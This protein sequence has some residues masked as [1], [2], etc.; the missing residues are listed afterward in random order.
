M[1]DKLCTINGVLMDVALRL[2]KGRMHAR[3]CNRLQ[4]NLR[5]QLPRRRCAAKSE[6]LR[7]ALGAP[8]P[9][10]TRDP[11]SH[12]HHYGL[13]QRLDRLLHFQPGPRLRNGGQQ[14]A[15]LRQRSSVRAGVRCH[16]LR[17]ILSLHKQR[18]DQAGPHR[19]GLQGLQLRSS[20]R[21]RR[22][23]LQLPQYPLGLCN[24]DAFP[25]CFFNGDA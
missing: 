6:Q 5:E 14:P 13:L 7:M 21:S 19:G 20:F 23:R 4:Q 17:C 24:A 11:S 9:R 25:P 15:L 2:P 12:A 22:V 1:R 3:N 16:L 10:P 18:L 8:P